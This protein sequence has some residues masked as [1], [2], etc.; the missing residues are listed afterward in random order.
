MQQPLA[1]RGMGLR[2]RLIEGQ[3]REES[4]ASKAK[5]SYCAKIL[6]YQFLYFHVKSFIICPVDIV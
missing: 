2:A 4:F 5:E 3:K 6:R 1:R